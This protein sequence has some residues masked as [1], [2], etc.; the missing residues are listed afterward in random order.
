M[1]KLV[2]HQGT[3]VVEMPPDL[4]HG[5]TVLAQ[6]EDLL[7]DLTDRSPQV[8]V[9]LTASPYLPGSL[10]GVLVRHLQRVRKSGGRMVVVSTPLQRE[11]FELSQLER[12]VTLTT[13]RDEALSVLAASA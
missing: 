5:E 9:D 4:D 12:L 3:M 7:V 10:L 11:V 2:Q 8:V 6:M 1:P 13:S